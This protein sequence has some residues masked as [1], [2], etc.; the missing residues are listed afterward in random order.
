MKSKTKRLTREKTMQAKKKG[1]VPFAKNKDTA[2]PK[3]E[4][5][6]ASMDQMKTKMLSALKAQRSKA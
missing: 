2:T 3:V 5:P 1:F 4:A 6:M